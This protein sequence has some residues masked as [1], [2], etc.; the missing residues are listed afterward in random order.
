MTSLL[1]DAP[2][3]AIRFSAPINFQ[4]E[5]YMRLATDMVDKSQAF[6]EKK[7]T[8]RKKP[9]NLQSFFS[10]PLVVAPTFPLILGVPKFPIL[11]LGSSKQGLKSE[12]FECMIAVLLCM[13]LTC[14]STFI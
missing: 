5:D 12:G 2:A 3:I 7:C 4:N 14:E 13:Q 1:P 6:I 8:Q 11:R 9:H 10:K